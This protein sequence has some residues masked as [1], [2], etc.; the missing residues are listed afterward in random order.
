MYLMPNS[1][2]QIEKT[3]PDLE[4]KLGGQISI[5]IQPKGRNKSQASKWVRKNLSGK[6]IF[7][8]DKC[9]PEGN[10]YDIYV[11]VKKN[12]GESYSVKSPLDTLK[13]LERN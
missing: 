10:D 5:D 7:F 4:A 6:I 3:F 11:D 1:L 8:G 9:T 2:D 13:L 12:G